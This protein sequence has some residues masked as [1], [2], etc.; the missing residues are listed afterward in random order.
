LIFG[1]TPKPNVLAQRFAQSLG[2]KYVATIPGFT[3]YH[4]ETVDGL[5]AIQTKEQFKEA[6]AKFLA[7]GGLDG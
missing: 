3:S 1:L 4:G 7:K 5:V 6:E 2:F